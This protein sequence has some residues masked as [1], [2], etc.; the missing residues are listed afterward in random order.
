MKT[1]WVPDLP[2]LKS[3]SGYL[4]WLPLIFA[5]ITSHAW[6]SKHMMM[7]MMNVYLYTAHITSCLMAVYNSIEWDRTSACEGAT[8]CR[9]Q[10]IF[11]PTHPP[12][13]CMKWEIDHNTGNYV[14]INMLARVC[15]LVEHFSTTYWN[16][17]GG[18]LKWVSCLGNRIF[19]SHRCVFCRTI[20]LPSF[21]G[22]GCKLAKIALFIYS[23]NIGLS[24][25]RH[26]SSHLHILM[27]ILANG[28]PPF[29][30]FMDFHVIH[31]KYQG[32]KIWS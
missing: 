8:G 15:G 2:H 20:S 7:M 3:F 23:Y 1:Y 22:L 19:Y 29:Y 27:Q 25:W 10:S 5:N 26:Q 18:D 16:Q 31:S 12:N 30:S 13:P 6:F 9:Y 11:D 28:K 17:V 32:V 14:H 24:V 21:N 4:F